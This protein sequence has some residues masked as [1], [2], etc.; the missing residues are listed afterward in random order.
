MPSPRAAL[1]VLLALAGLVALPAA[2][3]AHSEL[4]A[5]T[6]ADGEVI[7]G[8]PAVIAGEFSAPVDPGRSSMELRGPDGA[9]VARG[10]VPAGGSLTSMTI[11]EVPEIEPGTYTV[12]WTTVTADDNGV[13]RGTFRFTVEAAGPSPTPSPPPT[14]G[15]TATPGPPLLTPPANSPAATP[16]PSPAPEPAGGLG[17]MVVPLAVLGVVLAGGAVWLAALMRRR[18]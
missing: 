16:A 10:G 15:A 9:L 14:A 17:D 2:A 18:E 5:S 6:P 3:L 7:S 13:E 8:S 12:R 4:V 11:P 1:P